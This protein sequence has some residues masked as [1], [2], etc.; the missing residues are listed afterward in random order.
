MDV[1][2]RPPVPQGALAQNGAPASAGPIAEAFARYPHADLIQMLAA[3]SPNEVTAAGD[4]WAAIG[5]SLYDRANDLESQLAGFEEVWSGGAADLYKSMLVQLIAGIRKVAA[6]ALEIRDLIYT[7]GEALRA[8]WLTMPGVADEAARR[9]AVLV[10]TE[11]AQ[12]YDAITAALPAALAALSAPAGNGQ[13]GPGGPAHAQ[14]P[15]RP[16]GSVPGQP[17]VAGTGGVPGLFG[18]V[19]AAGIFAASAVLGRQFRPGA[20]GGPGGRVGRVGR[21]GRASLR[22]AARRP[23]TPGY[24]LPRLPCARRARLPGLS[25]A[26]YPGY[27]GYPGTPGM[28]GPG[29]PG[30][31]YPPGWEIPPGAGLPLPGAP[32]TDLPPGTAAPVPGSPAPGLPG[33]PGT[34]VPGMP[35]GPPPPSTPE[36]GGLGGGA[37][38]AGAALAGAGAGLALGDPGGRPG[39]PPPTLAGGQGAPPPSFT[40]FTAASAEGGRPAGGPM[41]PPMPMGMMGGADAAP[42][43]GRRIP[44]WLVETEDIWGESTVVAP[45][46]IGEEAEPGPLNPPW[47]AR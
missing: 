44:P 20:P 43:G 8:A 1:T 6:A 11:L 12:R 36:L 31:P 34:P 19:F 38:P 25:S 24:R 17:P 41:V 22:R 18:G 30:G 39:G 29:T 21:V 28:P 5:R 13:S 42:G 3:S 37:L 10:M 26:G 46:V 14:T 45:S 23:G 4:L 32:G 27:P 35:G 40:G 9:V 47:R 33:M 2:P 16:G 7:A 15:G